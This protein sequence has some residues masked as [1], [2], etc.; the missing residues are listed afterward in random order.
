MPLLNPNQISSLIRFLSTDA[1]KK[2]FGGFFLAAATLI[3][4]FVL[5]LL[6]G[7]IYYRLMAFGLVGLG[8]ATMTLMRSDK[9]QNQ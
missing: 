3:P 6:E 8:F 9:N 7:A 1:G 5:F 2:I 4:A